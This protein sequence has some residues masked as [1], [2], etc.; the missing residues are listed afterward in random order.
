MGRK[1]Y[2]MMKEVFD[3][4]PPVSV[5]TRYDNS[6]MFLES[7]DKNW[8]PP[9]KLSEDAGFTE[10]TESISSGTI[11][12]LREK[13]HEQRTITLRE[14]FRLETGRSIGNDWV[15][16]VPGAFSAT[17]AAEQALWADESQ[18]AGL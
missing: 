8:A 4:R 5:A 6:V 14:I 10:R 2:L 11:G 12:V 16:A 7:N 17:P 9:P 15:V 13:R 18:S 3:G 1:I